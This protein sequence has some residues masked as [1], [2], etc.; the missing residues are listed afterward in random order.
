[1]RREE[2][3]DLHLLVQVSCPPCHSLSTFSTPQ[4]SLDLTK[5][6]LSLILTFL[7]HVP[8]LC[9]CRPLRYPFSH[10][11]WANWLGQFRNTPV[12]PPSP[13]DRCVDIASTLHHYFLF[14]S[15]TIV[16]SALRG[17]L[18]TGV[19]TTSPRSVFLFTFFFVGI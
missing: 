10:L 16:L 19:C 15:N 2:A 13:Q 17:S 8:F 1:M 11:H 7:L 12:E 4:K 14:K 3:E 9:F 6:D 18:P 5:L